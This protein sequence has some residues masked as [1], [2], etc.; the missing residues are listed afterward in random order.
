MTSTAATRSVWRR[1]AATPERWRPRR[2]SPFLPAMRRPVRRPGD[3]LRYRPAFGITRGAETDVV[4]RELAN[5][6]VGRA[7]AAGARDPAV[8]RTAIRIHLDG[9]GDVA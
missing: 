2:S 6:R 4:K 8:R 5:E 3:I 9:D 7:V 1:W